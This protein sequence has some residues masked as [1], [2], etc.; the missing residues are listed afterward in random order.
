MD[1]IR[2]TSPSPATPSAAP[3]STYRPDCA[4]SSP[5]NAYDASDKL[6]YQGITEVDLA[7]GEVAPVNIEI[8]RVQD[9]LQPLRWTQNGNHY[10]SISATLTWEEAKEAAENLSFMGKPGHLATVTS[11]A[12]GTY[13]RDNLGVGWLGGFQPTDSPEPIWNWQW[14]TGETW[15]YNNWWPGGN[16]SRTPFPGQPDNDFKRPILTGSHGKLLG[17]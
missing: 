1:E 9:F 13:I 7:T 8:W 3:S 6:T 2:Q 14:V 16:I 4:E 5:L 10:A 12:E 11:A 15:D 17:R